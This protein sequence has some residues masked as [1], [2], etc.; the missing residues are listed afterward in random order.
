MLTL[1]N[2]H[3]FKTMQLQR[4]NT[5]STLQKHCPKKTMRTDDA[6]GPL[7]GKYGE[8]SEKL[9]CIQVGIP[10]HSN[11]DLLIMSVSVKILLYN[12]NNFII[13]YKTIIIQHYYVTD[14]ILS[15][16]G[17]EVQP[18]ANEHQG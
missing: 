9:P 7:Q 10:S 12:L 1:S 16:T 6:S 11:P 4:A 2:T 5:V 3:Y 15:C 13:L 17:E 8:R 18:P 14:L